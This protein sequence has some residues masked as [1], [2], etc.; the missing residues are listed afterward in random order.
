[1]GG[2][3]AEAGGGGRSGRDL[4]KLL[5][6]IVV[7][8]VAGVAGLVVGRFSALESGRHD[9]AIEASGPVPASARTAGYWTCSM[10][11]EVKR[12]GPGKCPKC[13]MDL[14]HEDGDV[15]GDEERGVPRL[16]L[17]EAAR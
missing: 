17:S 10:H 15:G 7:A 4:R 2:S 11:P 13:F 3:E 16:V 1:M 12:P 5:T 8:A 6:L 14:Y 9:R